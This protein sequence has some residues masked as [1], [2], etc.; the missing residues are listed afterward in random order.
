M[1]ISKTDSPT[2]SSQFKKTRNAYRPYDFL[3]L[4]KK[5][6]KDEL[7]TEEDEYYL[8]RYKKRKDGTLELL[9]EIKK[10]ITVKKDY[11]NSLLNQLNHAKIKRS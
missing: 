6:T 5:K 9:Y 11:A 3:D 10:E 2:S 8:R 7:V 1:K 4:L